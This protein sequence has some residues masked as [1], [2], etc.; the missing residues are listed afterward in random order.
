MHVCVY[1]FLAL[2]I[3]TI[4]YAHA[5]SVFISVSHSQS[6]TSSQFS[7]QH[8]GAG[9]MHTWNSTGQHIS[10]A[11]SAR[12]SNRESHMESDHVTTPPNQRVWQ[13]M[14]EI[15]HSSFQH[16]YDSCVASNVLCSL[17]ILVY[18]TGKLDQDQD[19]VNVSRQSNTRKTPHPVPDSTPPN[20]IPV[21]VSSHKCF[22]Q[23]L[24]SRLSV[25]RTGYNTTDSDSVS[26]PSILTHKLKKLTEIWHAS[27]ESYILCIDAFAIHMFVQRPRALLYAY[28]AVLRRSQEWFS[29]ASTKATTKAI[30]A[31]SPSYPL[32]SQMISYRAISNTYDAW[33][34][35]Q[36]YDYIKEMLIWGTNQ[37][38]FVAPDGSQ[39]PFYSLS[40]PEMLGKVSSICKQLD[41]NV[42]V[43]YPMDATDP[44]WG[45]YVLNITKFDSLFVPGGDPG[46]SSPS[47]VFDAIARFVP[48]LRQIHPNAQ[49][50]ISNQGFNGTWLPEFYQIVNQRTPSW[51]TGV[52]YGPHTRDTISQTRKHI[53]SDLP[54]RHYPDVC[55][56][57]KAQF[58]QPY[59]N[60]AFALTESRE[61]VNPRVAQMHRIFLQMQPYTIGFGTYTDGAT[62]DLNMVVWS[63]LGWNDSL[64]VQQAVLDYST[65]Y[66]GHEL[67]SSFAQLWLDLE[68]AWQNV[69]FPNTTIAG[70]FERAKTIRT[71]MG[72]ESYKS[73]WR[74]Q[75]AYYR[76][77]Y[78]AYEQLRWQVETNAETSAMQALAEA[79]QIGSLAAIGKA[80]S[81]LDGGINATHSVAGDF[82]KQT[83]AIA[84]DLY[85][86]I[87]MQLSVK[88]YHASGLGRGASLD[89]IDVPLNNIRYLTQQF[90]A[91]KQ[92]GTE[93]S[94][95][96]AI[97]A[98]VDW[99]EP[100]PGALYDNLG[101]ILQEPHLVKGVGAADDPSFYVSSLDSF[102]SA[103]NVSTEPILPYSWYSWA[104]SFYDSSLSLHYTG[105]DPTL[106][107]S[108]R[109]VFGYGVKDAKMRLIANGSKLVHD[110]MAKPYPPAP[111]TI[112]LLHE[113]TSTGTLDLAWNQLP[114]DGGNGRGCQLSETWLIPTEC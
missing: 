88:L 59:W 3:N 61:V 52:V 43:W 109:V 20:P 21:S 62:D 100:V 18:R 16:E 65:R 50:W 44:N 24:S 48:K 33:D 81:I 5:E 106:C 22:L 9:Q 104:E 64:S 72:D 19:L 107:Y 97:R 80:Q 10:F 79:P 34:V 89:S 2:I 110:Y 114:G 85:H 58:P 105:L 95:L 14:L 74:F 7:R 77:A 96:A 91:I 68:V 26:D 40:Q 54:I 90:S 8:D 94:R 45:Q 49:I 71:I 112:H 6:E 60:P 36:M 12:V 111:V 13:T 4:H 46:S 30:V 53:R 82:R 55:H 76:A 37:M 87:G 83:F 73:N 51:L 1:I 31:A 78:D 108:L 69:P 103:F 41:M 39:S 25:Y 47:V 92:M 98:L 56:Q 99:Q 42:S 17:P 86:S 32:R 57:L 102:V 11:P 63:I 84:D 70:N 75:E 29:T 28:S 27:D 66:V 101:S 113:L 67:A 35:D 15:T 93:S 38:E 23:V